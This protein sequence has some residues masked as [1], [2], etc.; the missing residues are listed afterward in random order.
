MSC[1]E[2]S[3]AECR[4]WHAHGRGQTP[5]KSGIRAWLDYHCDYVHWVS[6]CV[7]ISSGRGRRR[8]GVGVEC[9]CWGLGTHTT[10]GKPQEAPHLSDQVPQLLRRLCTGRIVASL[11]NSMGSTSCC[12]PSLG[13]LH[14]W[15]R[16][17][18]QG[19]QMLALA[20]RQSLQEYHNVTSVSHCQD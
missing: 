14:S 8:E 10:R 20:L 5:R 19:W 17:R 1:C 16:F 11:G 2:D 18:P 3:T 12:R 6:H 9:S 4:N 15:R 13:C 7:N